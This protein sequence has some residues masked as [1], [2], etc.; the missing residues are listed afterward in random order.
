MNPPQGD[1]Y[2]L[3]KT[4][5]LMT[6]KLHRSLFIHHDVFSLLYRLVTL[7]YGMKVFFVFHWKENSIHVMKKSIYSKFWVTRE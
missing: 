3:L 5:G 6:P 2:M 1:G 4:S 7:T